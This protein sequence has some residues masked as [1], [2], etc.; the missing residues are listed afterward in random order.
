MPDAT[1]KSPDETRAALKKLIA[2]NEEWLMERILHY[3][4]LYDFTRY[5][6][7]LKEAWRASIEGLSF[8]LLATLDVTEN[9]PE[10]GP[11]EDWLN[12]PC[13]EFGR[14]EAEKHRNR[15]ISLAMF[16]ALMKYYRQSYCDLLRGA[17]F[18]AD[19]NWAELFLNRVFDR[20]EISFSHCWSGVDTEQ[21]IL[22]LQDQNRQLAN[23]KNKFLTLFESNSMPCFLVNSL[24]HL[25][26]MNLSAARV[27]GYA[28]SAGELYYQAK[29]E[30][31]VPEWLLD[32]LI[33][34][35]GFEKDEELFEKSFRRAGKAQ[36]FE[37]HLRRMLDVSGK[38]SGIVVSMADVTTRMHGQQELKKAHSDLTEAQEQMLQR[39]KMAS[40]GCLTSGMAH[41]I[42][43]P[44]AVVLQNLQVIEQRLKPDFKRN[45]DVAKECGL[46]LS[47]MQCYI[48]RQKIDS[49]H[50]AIRNSGGRAA[51]IVK[52]LYGFSH[53]SEETPVVLNI[54]DL[55]DTTIERM[56][57]GENFCCDFDFS[58]ILIERDYAESLAVVSGRK[59]ELQQVFHS[60]LE[61]GV[62]AMTAQ[63]AG[64]EKQLK[65]VLR[66]RQEGAL[67]VLEIQDNGPGIAENLQQ[68]IFDPFFTTKKTGDGLGLGL[69]MAY[70]IV[71]RHSGQLD[72]RS[73]PGE[74]SSFIIKLPLATSAGE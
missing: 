63:D 33:S 27:F 62:Q 22:D 67:V 12:D 9:I 28:L 47:A 46:D 45:V 11:D 3:A 64:G 43:N 32:E 59:F 66:C 8:S 19:R 41:E 69:S 53:R 10:F 57:G 25:D 1:Q 17:D 14:I 65:F 50:Q 2:G 54:C 5:T 49:M 20:I 40:I 42:N 35:S 68:K 21:L 15:G 52:K 38:Y 6:S 29:K 13:G 26:C 23:E 34:F 31:R 4:T 30:E 37:V 24:G 73:T 18:S 51:V 55:L 58:K 61:N 48:K 60:I 56:R 7:T 70:K 72:V 44:L 71:Q 74:G 39:E 16:L 36:V